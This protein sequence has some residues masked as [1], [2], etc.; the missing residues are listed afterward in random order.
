MLGMAGA[1][2]ALLA[3]GACNNDGNSNAGS[4]MGADGN[5][6]KPGTNMSSDTAPDTTMS[7]APAD[8]STTTP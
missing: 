1:L 8:T 3:L 5:H 4:G 6:S 2:S 7:S